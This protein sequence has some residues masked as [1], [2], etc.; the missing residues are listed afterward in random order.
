M[1]FAP[2]AIVHLLTFAAWLSGCASTPPA[3]PLGPVS[4]AQEETRVIAQDLASMQLR[5]SGELTS[6]QTATL[7]K[8][9]Y[10]LVSNGQV[11]EKG[12]AALGVTLVPGSPT[13][14]SFMASTPSVKSPEDLQALSDKG[15]ALL[16]AVRGTLTVRSGDSERTLPFAASRQVRGPR[17][18]RVK[19]LAM[20]GARY[21]DEQ[22]DLVMRLGVE[23]PNPFPVRLD[24]LTW[25]LGIQGRRLGEGTLG[26][27]DI[28]DAAATGVYPVE[29][30]V[31]RETWGP[32]VRGL[33]AKGTLPYEVAGEL[34]GPL[35]RVP[36]SLSGDVKLNVSR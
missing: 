8:A 5:Y 6:P 34:T 17:L 3:V 19:V 29:V 18:P 10:E 11:L 1:R 31:T 9:D 36:Y 21:S 35:V 26:K 20:E 2:R 14:F 25:A 12:T 28:V 23:N 24:G 4:L 16:V 32:E 33:I 13:A 15:G 7:E 27:Q 22:V 30:A